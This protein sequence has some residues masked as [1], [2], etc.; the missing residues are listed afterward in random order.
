MGVSAN[1]LRLARGREIGDCREV[2][3]SVPT[4]GV[5]NGQKQVGHAGLRERGVNVLRFG[6]RLDRDQV[7]FVGY[8]ACK[9]KQR[10]LCVK[11]FAPGS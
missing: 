11:Q 1:A 8:D 10:V 9:L 3:A 7:F 4:Y 2:N 6:F 5:L